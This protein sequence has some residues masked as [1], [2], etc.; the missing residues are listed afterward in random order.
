MP[1]AII[2]DLG[3]GLVLRK[4]T[5]ADVEVLVAFN[6][7]V[8]ADSGRPR[9]DPEIAA[10]T[11]DL[12]EPGH[13]TTS[14]DDFTIVEDVHSGAIV[15]SIVLIAQTWL[16][17]GLP[18]PVGQPE[19][20]G[21]HPAYRNRGLVRA[22]FETLHRWSAERGQAMQVIRGIPY[23]YRQ[24]GYEPAIAML[25]RRAGYASDILTLREGEEE[26]YRVRRAIE[27]DLPFIADLYEQATRRHRI[28]CIRSMDLWRYDLSGRRQTSRFYREIQVIETLVGKPIGYPTH[29]A[30]LMPSVGGYGLEI[31]SYELRP[32]CDWHAVTTTVLR[33]VRM[34]GEEYAARDQT[35]PVVAFTFRLGADHPVYA[36]IPLNLPRTTWR[37]AWYV[38]VPDL[39]KF[40][41]LLAPALEARLAGSVVAGYGGEL[42]VSFYRS[43]LRLIF[44]DGHLAHVQPWTPTPDDTGPASFPGLTFL[45]LLFGYRDLEEL[46]YAFVDCQVFGNR[47]RALLKALFPKQVS[48]VRAYT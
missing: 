4:A 1:T 28:A 44:D 47:N 36:A 17:A 48:N 26:T 13:P 8:L 41:Q 30:R 12:A 46:E 18:I 24:F 27:G 7:D 37:Y 3:D 23:F 43:G 9:P 34:V 45:Q 40:L 2:R 42:K 19:I 10:V 16:Y 38:R 32:G 14:V 22:Q 35:S 29:R 20:V 15:S 33:Y 21:T 6:A 11:R 39:A 31:D 5:S 25:E